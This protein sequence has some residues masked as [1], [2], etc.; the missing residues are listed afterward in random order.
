MI[1]EH[2]ANIANLAREIAAAMETFPRLNQ[3]DRLSI[4]AGCKAKL[5]SLE[6]AFVK[7]LAEMRYPQ[8]NQ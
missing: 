4:A 2:A 7:L 3:R 6:I 8:K 1:N 5:A